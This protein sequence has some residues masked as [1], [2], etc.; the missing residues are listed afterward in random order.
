MLEILCHLKDEET[1]DFRARLGHILDN[2]GQP[3]PPTDPEGWIT[4]RAYAAQDY[5]KKLESFLNERYASIQWL[6]ALESPRWDNA[7]EHPKAGP[8]TAKMILYN[9]VAHDLHHIRQINAL[10]HAYLLQTS[11]DPLRYA[12]A[13]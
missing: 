7:Y 5:E 1:D 3:L 12:G 2:P 9:W 13:W 6:Q 8:V 11:G 4:A 10:Q